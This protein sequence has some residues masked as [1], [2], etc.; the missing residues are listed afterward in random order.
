MGPD[1]YTAVSS[2][3][4][5]VH[6]RLNIEWL[7]ELILLGK[8]LRRVLREWMSVSI[9]A[10]ITPGSQDIARQGWAGVGTCCFW[11]SFCS[12]PDSL[13]CLRFIIN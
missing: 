3:V 8:A 4:K 13:Y 11:F 5:W 7:L 10:L 12:A 6:R 9:S 1:L 2:S